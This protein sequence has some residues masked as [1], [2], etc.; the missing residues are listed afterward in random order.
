MSDNQI[1]LQ[2]T[3][4]FIREAGDILLNG[5]TENYSVEMKGKSD[6]VTEIDRRCENFLKDKIH[7]AF[8]DHRILAEESKAEENISEIK[9]IIDPIDGT[10]NYLHRFPYFCISIAIE[11][12]DDILVGV[13]YDPVRDELFHAISDIDGAFLNGMPLQVSET[14]LVGRS[15]LVTGFPYEQ[16][17]TFH[18]NFLLHKYVYERSHGVRRTG[19]A[20]L[21]LCYVAA[22]RTDGYWEFS[23]KPWDCAAGALLVTKAGGKVTTI[24]GRGYS[25]YI[26]SVL[27]TNG[28]IHHEMLEILNQEH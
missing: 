18:K 11:Q 10:T 2:K 5:M 15:L 12:G 23:L 25:P 20:A 22:G 16:G 6:P 19:A 21:D 4:E 9:W 1:Y 17:D 26:P 7:K 13:V 8:P 14:K 28:H 27:A 3:I 24:G